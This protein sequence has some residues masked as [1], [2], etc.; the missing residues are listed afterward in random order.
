MF[1]KWRWV[2]WIGAILLLAACQPAELPP[3]EPQPTPQV[4]TLTFPPALRW[5]EPAFNACAL[6]EPVLSVLVVD[7]TEAADVNLY[8]GEPDAGA[9]EVFLLGEDRLVLVSNQANPASGL[10]LRE[11]QDMFT[12]STDTW[13]NSEPLT[14]YVLPEGH[15]VQVAF[16]AALGRAIPK[17]VAIQVAPSLEAM[18]QYVAD[19]P[20]ALGVLPRSWLNEEVKVLD[21]EVEA[22]QPILAGY[23]G[24]RAEAFVRCLQM[25]AVEKMGE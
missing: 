21:W 20:T 12:G 11:A 18:R 19:D 10:S 24:N 5:L 7:E 2:V 3:A 15:V 13:A 25:A 9:G 14:V 17:S 23:R 8:W 16:E 4:L 1:S 6:E 22:V